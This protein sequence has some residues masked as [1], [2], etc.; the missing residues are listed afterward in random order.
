MPLVLREVPGTPGC[1]QNRP[2]SL[3]LGRNAHLGLSSWVTQFRPSPLSAG[4]PSL[5]G[6]LSLHAALD[7]PPGPAMSSLLPSAMKSTPRLCTD[8][9]I[10]TRLLPPLPRDKDCYL[11]LSSVS[12]LSTVSMATSPLSMLKTRMVGEKIQM[13]RQ[14]DG[15]TEGGREAWMF[16]A[17]TLEVSVPSTPIRG[18]LVL[19]SLHK[20]YNTVLKQ[21]KIIWLLFAE[22]CGADAAEQAERV[23]YV[24]GWPPH[25]WWG[26]PWASVGSTGL[27]V[28]TPPVHIFE[29]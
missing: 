26:R 20:R 15:G 18:A 29:H 14:T 19:T 8:Y 5:V 17:M 7:S 23:S 28:C 25:S 1:P 13:D 6:V 24:R 10:N 11:V 12:A 4:T 3:G 9:N 21:E 22:Q 16:R 27:T 2:H